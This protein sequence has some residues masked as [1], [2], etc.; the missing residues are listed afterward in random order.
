MVIS[1]D[2]QTLSNRTEE[3]RTELTSLEAELKA[4]RAQGEEKDL[5]VVRA[6]LARE[7]QS[8]TF[9]WTQVRGLLLSRLQEASENASE[10]QRQ[11]DGKEQQLLSEL[12]DL[13]QREEEL[14]RKSEDAQER[15]ATLSRQLAQ[16]RKIV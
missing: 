12:T 4:L 1:F 8:A 15:V 9:V 3:M 10:L 7:T 16:A 2:S 6:L 13:R 5:A 11:R 14:V